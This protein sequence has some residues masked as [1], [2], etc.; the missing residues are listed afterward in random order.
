MMTE[1]DDFLR[2]RREAASAPEA[3]LIADHGETWA[4]VKSPAH[5]ELIIDFTSRLQANLGDGTYYVV[6]RLEQPTVHRVASK[7]IHAT[8]A[9]NPAVQKA[10]KERRKHMKRESVGQARLFL[11]GGYDDPSWRFARIGGTWHPVADLSRSSFGSEWQDKD[12]RRLFNAMTA[13]LSRSSD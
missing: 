5:A 1:L 6:R 7:P 4:I 3:Q 11:I 8:G 2:A 10:Y 12:R 13:H 9:Y